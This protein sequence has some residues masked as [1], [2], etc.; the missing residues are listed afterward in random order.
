MQIDDRIA[1]NI[2]CALIEDKQ[3]QI[4]VGDVKGDMRVTIFTPPFTLC[5]RR[6]N[7]F[8]Y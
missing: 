6:L 5:V 1:Q 3:I 4:E 2:P 7:L 8:D